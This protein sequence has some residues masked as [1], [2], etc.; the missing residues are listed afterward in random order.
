AETRP[1]GEDLGGEPDQ[2]LLAALRR[3][4][5]E[6]RIA[7]R[8]QARETRPRRLQ[9][10]IEEPGRGPESEVEREVRSAAGDVRGADLL[11]QLGE[12][13]GH[14]IERDRRL[15]SVGD[16]DFAHCADPLLDP[17]SDL[18]KR[19]RAVDRGKLYPEIPWRVVTR[20]EVDPT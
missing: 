17:L 13:F 15:R 14:G 5:A 8:I 11:A 7:L 1:A 12:I 9:E 2:L 6:E 20:G 10:G 19:G 16:G 3:Q 18:G 4:S